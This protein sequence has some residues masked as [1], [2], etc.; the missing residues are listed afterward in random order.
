MKKHTSRAQAKHTV[1]DFV[2]D[3]IDIMATLYMNNLLCLDCSFIH[4]LALLRPNLETIVGS[5]I[6][7]I[8]LTIFRRKLLYGPKLIV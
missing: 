5:K 4:I 8:M 3:F 6:L 7:R 1:L 2:M